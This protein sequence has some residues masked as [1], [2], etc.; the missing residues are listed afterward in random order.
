MSSSV[1]GNDDKQDN[2][3]N[4]RPK[5]HKFYM[6]YLSCIEIAEGLN[7]KYREKF[8]SGGTSVTPADVLQKIIISCKASNVVEIGTGFGTATIAIAGCRNVNSVMSFDIKA[9]VWPKYLAEIF[10][11]EDKI[12]TVFTSSKAIHRIVKNLKFDFAYIDGSHI[13]PYVLQDF[14]SVKHCGQVLFDD[15]Y[16]KNVLAVIKANGG[17]T[18]G[19][20]FGYWN[21]YWNARNKYGRIKKIENKIDESD[22]IIKNG[23]LH[24]DIS[25]LK[26]LL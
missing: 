11:L 13:P 22:T 26:N 5:A 6:K 1:S 14:E 12:E 4:K 24:Q 19:K 25:Y 3:K 18:I 10:K 15:A 9:S 20:R 21:G 17:I 23:H 16:S 7:K 2:N 8:L